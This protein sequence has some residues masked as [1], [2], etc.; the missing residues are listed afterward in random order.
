MNQGSMKG[1]GGS[2]DGK[3]ED[4]TDGIDNR[5]RAGEGTRTPLNT[6]RTQSYTEEALR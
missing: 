4:S 1:Y 3:K 6:T 5:W 2:G